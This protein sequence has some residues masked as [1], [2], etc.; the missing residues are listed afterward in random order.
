MKHKK[1]I[2]V[3]RREGI[4]CRIDKENPLND[5][6]LVTLPDYTFMDGRPTP[7][8]VSFNLILSGA[9]LNKS[10]FPL[11]SNQMQRLMKQ[12]E[13]AGKIAEQLGE[14]NFAKERHAKMVQE[15]EDKRNAILNSKL[16]EKGVK[17]LKKQA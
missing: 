8:G 15:K 16:K 1:A 11:Q 13:W 17:L 3:A 7:L 14:L 5:S 12:R 2:F 10:S 6:P 4:S 9:A